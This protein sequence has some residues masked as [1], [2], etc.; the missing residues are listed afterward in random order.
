LASSIAVAIGSKNPAKIEGVRRAFAHF[1][2]DARLDYVDVPGTN[3][4]PIGAEDTTAGAVHRAR[5]AIDF[6]RADLGVGVEAGLFKANETYFDYHQAAIV[7][8]SNRVSL[9]QSMAFPL[10]AKPID[11][12]MKEGAELEELAIKLTGI[13]LIGDKG[14]II[15]H[16]TRGTVSRSDLTEQCV[17]AAL[18]PRL[19][20]R[21]YGF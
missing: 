3:P 8:A 14:G 9:G 16:L 15:N 21:L 20:S 12:M 18:I 1:Y 17:I 5:S 4:Q 2:P 13:E 11:K 10:P 7:D 19:N 6:L